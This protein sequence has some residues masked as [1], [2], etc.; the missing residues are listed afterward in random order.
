VP[1]GL[2]RERDL[3]RARARAATERGSGETRVRVERPIRPRW[4]W[5]RGADDACRLKKYALTALQQPTGAYGPAFAPFRN[6]ST[7]GF[8]TSSKG[9]RFASLYVDRSAS[10]DDDAAPAFGYAKTLVLAPDATEVRLRVLL[11]RTILE[12]FADDGKAA[13]TA[14]IYSVDGDAAGVGAYGS[15]GT[16]LAA[17]ELHEM[18]GAVLDAPPL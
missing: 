10:S 15:D 11:D 7:S 18:G 3:R 14:R 2:R 12:A 5:T 6:G 4:T 13:V 9:A 1:R 8:K 16:T 17:F